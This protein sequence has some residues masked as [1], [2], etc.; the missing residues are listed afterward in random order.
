MA[1]S[2]TAAP[3]VDAPRGEVIGIYDDR[4]SAQKIQQ[5][6]A[7]AGISKQKVLVDDHISPS[8]QLEALST[9]SGPE[10]GFL[11]GAFY[12]GA[13]GLVIA[14]SAPFLIDGMA[15]NSASNRLLI[16]G[17]TVV[18]GLLGLLFGRQIYNAQP[19]E[20]KQKSD[21]SIPRTFRI[22]VNGSQSEIE[23]AKGVVRDIEIYQ[24]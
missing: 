24:K 4:Q 14:L 11:I 17:A 2:Q 7:S 13:V 22:V 6:I 10:A 9:T 12:G 15:V 20:Q 23:R 8:T 1:T 18:G 16:L 3:N 5:V 19:K 21:P